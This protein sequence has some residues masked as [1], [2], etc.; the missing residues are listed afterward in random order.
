MSGV[1]VLT[2]A[3]RKTRGTSKSR[4]ARLNGDVPAVLYGH[5]K[6]NVSLSIPVEQIQGA[7]RHGSHFVE[8]RG[9]VND[10]ALI[11]AVQWDAFGMEIL[12]VDFARA[13]AGESAEITLTVELRGDAPG[14]HEGGVVQQLIHEVEIECPVTKIPDKLELNINSLKLG[15]EIAASS[16]ELPEGAKLLI[17]EDSTIVQCVVVQA[18]AEEEEGAAGTAEPEVIGRKEDDE[19]D[20]GE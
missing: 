19:T 14:S 5:G 3:L 11:R 17:D 13:Q 1:E 7:I 20:A 4:R 6:E 8:L 12:H 10:E 2:T 18:E 9:E 16:L 15:D